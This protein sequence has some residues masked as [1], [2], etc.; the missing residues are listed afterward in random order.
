MLRGRSFGNCAR[1]TFLLR[2]HSFG[3]NQD[4]RLLPS[5]RNGSPAHI[6][7]SSRT[8]RPRSSN[9]RPCRNRVFILLVFT[10]NPPWMGNGTDNAL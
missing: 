10:I 1:K 7:I 3:A 5:R 8:Y 2:N 4:S 9:R 6:K